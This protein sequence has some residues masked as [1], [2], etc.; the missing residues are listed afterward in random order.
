M[1]T[2]VPAI[3]LGLALAAPAA[4]QIWQEKPYPQWSKSDCEKILRDSPWS[5][6]RTL[7]G[8][9]ITPL[10]TNPRGVNIPPPLS[11]TDPSFPVPSATP[12][13][14]ET[15]FGNPQITYVAQLWSARP[16]REAF[17]RNEQLDPRVEQ[18]SA[19]QKHKLEE[20]HARIL[21]ASFDEYV[22]IRVLYSS[23]VKSYDV[24]LA[25]FW[26]RQFPEELKQRVYLIGSG[27]RKVRPAQIHIAKGAGREFQLIFPR[28]VEGQLIV[29]PGDKSLAV[30]F[31]H[32][33]VGNITRQR[34]L[35]EF[36]VRKMLVAGK[37]E[38]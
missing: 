21:G 35:L 26:Q 22:V 9:N 36:D 6:G 16:L 2:F 14:A 24:D 32:P 34:V 18:F 5:R 25:N 27:G 37:L 30:E 11:P 12:S 4:A 10:Q 1:K 38:Y 31:E 33:N 20:H 17:V 3:V 19:E 23:T 13:V 8:V 29:E 7:T 15:R 28:F